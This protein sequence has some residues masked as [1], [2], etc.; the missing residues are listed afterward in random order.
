MARARATIEHTI[1]HTLAPLRCGESVRAR[2]SVGGLVRDDVLRDGLFWRFRRDMMHLA[3]QLD[4]FARQ[5]NKARALFPL[6]SPTGLLPA[7][8]LRPFAAAQPVLNRCPL[9]CR[10]IHLVPPQQVALFRESGAQHYSGDGSVHTW[11]DAHPQAAQQCHCKPLNDV[12]EITQITDLNAILRKLHRHHPR[13]GLL[14]YYELTAPRFDMHEES[15][16]AFGHGATPVR[17]CDC[18]HF[19][20]T[21]QMWKVFFSEMYEQVRIHMTSNVNGVTRS[22]RRRRSRIS[23]RRAAKVEE[24]RRR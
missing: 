21:P 18:V 6:F 11:S 1:E 23:P 19:C 15:F 3:A 7:R 8:R 12:H 24:E 14:H 16:C 17:C 9:V 20:Y 2:G 10:S 22:V 4:L 13:I 5:P